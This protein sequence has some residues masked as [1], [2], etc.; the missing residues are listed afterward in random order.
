MDVLFL[1]RLQFALTIMFH[2]LFPP[3]TI[4][5]G[6]VIVHLLAM[7]LR[8]RRGDLRHGGA[9]LDQDLRPQ[10]RPRRGHRHRHGVRVRHQ[11]GRLLPLRRRR[12][13]LG[14]GRRGGVR[15]LPRVGLPRRA[16]LRLGPGVAPLPLLLGG[17]GVAGVDLLLG[18]DHRRQ[19]LAADAGRL[20]AAR[21]RDQGPGR[22][23]APRSPTSGRWCSTRRRSTGSST[24]GS[25]PSSSAPS[26]S[27]RSPPGTCSRDATSS[28]PGARSP[29]RSSSAP[30]FSLAQGVS[31]DLQAKGVGRPPAGQARRLRRGSSPPA[32]RP[33]LYLWGWPDAEAGEVRL[34]RRRPG[35]AELAALRRRRRRR[36]RASTSLAPT[37]GT[38]PVWLTFQSYHLMV[39]IGVLLRRPH[40]LRL[41]GALARHAL[42]EAL[43]ALGASSSPS[44]P[45]SPPTSS[46]GWRRRWAASRGS[47]TPGWSTAPWSAACA[48]TP[49]CPRRCAPA[50]CWARS[51]SFA[52]IYALLFVLWVL[53]LNHKIQQGPAPAGPE[54]EGDDG[55]RP[56]CHRGAD[57]RSRGVAD[58]GEVRGRRAPLARLDGG[59]GHGPPRALVRAPRRAAHRLRHPRRLRPRGGHPPPGRE[60]RHRAAGD[61]QLDRPHL[62][63]QRGLAGHLRRRPVRRLPGG[64]RHGLLGL[65]RRLHAGAVR[66]HPAGGV[67]GVPGQTGAVAVAA[68]LGRRLL[69]GE[70][71]GGRAVRGGDR[72]RS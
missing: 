66:P 2:Y 47:S 12:L 39:A 32:P 41:V 20:R 70:L 31:G 23:S 34:R 9:V 63:R 4:G 55:A 61:P 60:V 43:A 68:V 25:A 15:L 26:S 69:L 71:A 45:P 29:A 5:L 18:V 65:L 7:R 11:L 22:S 30:S 37:W 6:L 52:L 64:L 3:L 40:P 10:L 44:C 54:P 67:A 58:R 62:G 59:S 56:A 14:A 24:S 51:S 36:C 19:L 57:G 42:R 33:P 17:D 35:H 46:A 16:A 1:S 13:R 48:P 38:P 49:R 21:P 28:S 72:R 50:R 27:C 53:V 8:T